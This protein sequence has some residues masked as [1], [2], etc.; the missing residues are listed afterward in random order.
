M[1]RLKTAALLLL[2]VAALPANAAPPAGF[3]KEVEALAS[4]GRHNPVSPSPSLKMARRRWPRDG[5]CANWAVQRRLMPIPP[6]RPGSTGK[7]VTA[8]A[9]A[10]LVDEGRIR[11]D[12]PVIK[13][14]PW[15]RMYDPG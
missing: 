10:I 5:V 1:M 2:S 12:D 13:H 8:A 6:S 7:A 3:E 4:E 15:F 14:M 9:L 11:W